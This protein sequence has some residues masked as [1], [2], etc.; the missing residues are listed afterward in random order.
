M[1]LSPIGYGFVQSAHSDLCSWSSLLECDRFR[2]LAFSYSEFAVSRFSLGIGAMH[3]Q[4]RTQPVAM[5]LSAPAN[6]D[7]AIE[8][9]KATMKLPFTLRGEAILLSHFCSTCFVSDHQR[10]CFHATLDHDASQ[11]L[12]WFAR[13]QPKQESF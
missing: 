10:S 8:D 1:R 5:T 3:A 11:K 12:D 4:Q 2:S 6:S 13:Q 7:R 9:H